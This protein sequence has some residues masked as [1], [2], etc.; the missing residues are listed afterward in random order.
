MDSNSNKC[1]PCNYKCLNC[2]LVNNLSKCSL[3]DIGSYLDLTTLSCNICP[4]GAQT[5]A[6]NTIIQSCLAGY[7]KSSN[8]MFCTPCTNNCL[9]CPVSTTNCTVCNTGYYINSGLCTV[10]N[11]PNCLACTGVGTNVFCTACDNGFYKFNNTLCSACPSNCL[12]CQNSSA[13]ISCRS[14]YYIQNGGCSSVPTSVLISNCA[15]YSNLTVSG[16]YPCSS[17]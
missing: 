7:L 10:C 9:T 2:Q 8:S 17:C 5:C 1:Q 15:T 12:S 4:L 14:N 11:I 16:G 6:S 13:C 3:C